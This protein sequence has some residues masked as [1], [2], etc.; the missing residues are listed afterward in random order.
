ML[1]QK[2][3]KELVV[4]SLISETTRLNLQAFLEQAKSIR[5][6]RE[7]LSS[8]YDLLL[9][10]RGIWD[11]LDKKRKEEDKVEKE[12]I[13]TRKAGY[14][15]IMNPI[16]E[17][18]EAADPNIFA[19]NTEILLE[20]REIGNKIQK[21]I[22]NRDSLAAFINATIRSIVAAPD[23][24]DLVR[25]QKLIG[26]AMSH[27][28]KYETYAHILIEVSDELL[29][30]ID[31]RKRLITEN[32]KI[33]KLLDE[34]TANNDHPAELAYKQQMELG[35]R[36]LEENAGG[37]SDSAFKKVSDLPLVGA[38][39]V[40][41]AIKPRTHRWAWRVDDIELLYKKHPDL[42]VKEPDTKPINAFMK[43]KVEA[44]ELS[45]Y[46]DNEYNG[47][48]LYRKPFYVSVK[49]TQKDA[50]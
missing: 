11:Y 48:V 20:E 32:E 12:I 6:D 1:P 4:A 45:E 26:S 18:L 15:E 33:Q 44:N 17:L 9:K 37:I 31:G 25:I 49:N 40:S 2:L 41:K 43:E 13:A 35:Q 42:V 7:S 19:L 10:L 16:A 50:S 23:N 36:E 34:A 24:K 27:K 14:E 8:N 22:D 30:L 38:E 39:I 5:Y 47:L 3:T 21:Q 46:G 29:K 28:E